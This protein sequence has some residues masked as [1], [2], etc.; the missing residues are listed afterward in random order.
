MKNITRHGVLLLT[1]LATLVTV[2]S[3]II[4]NPQK[5]QKGQA[6]FS[7][8]KLEIDTAKR[9]FIRLEP[10]PI[11]LSISNGTA[12]PI[13][14]STTLL[15]G[16]DFVELFVKSEGGEM[17]KI[18]NLTSESM[19]ISPGIITIKPK[20]SY[21]EDQLLTLALD[22]IFPQAGVYYIEA[23]L[24]DARTKETIRSNQVTLT[25]AEPEGLDLEAFNYL[26]GNAN[27][28]SFFGGI[29]NSTPEK[30]ETFALL[31][32]ESV[33]GD[34][35]AYMLGRYYW[36]NEKYGKAHKHFDKL[37]KKDDFI[38]ANMVKGYLSKI[39]EKQQVDVNN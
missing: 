6:G 10:V 31:F 27:P 26:T 22:K 25:V 15:L 38:F 3:A 32:G 2:G 34:Y 24:H 35:V 7:D 12:Q 21:R 28:S 30:A 20:E 29:A 11:I 18:K 9:R 36:V 23:V 37:S 14:A 1:L 19:L 5:G 39:K 33:Y 13:Q 8:L 17:R 16:A 4:A